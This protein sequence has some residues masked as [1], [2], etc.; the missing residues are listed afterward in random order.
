MKGKSIQE[1]RIAK[2]CRFCDGR[3]WKM[4]FW[5]PESCSHCCGTGDHDY[6]SNGVITYKWVTIGRI[7]S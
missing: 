3:G 5:K 4:G 1:L 6:R 2:P 7:E